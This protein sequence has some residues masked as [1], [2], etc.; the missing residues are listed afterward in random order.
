MESWKQL[1]IHSG[2]RITVPR[3]V[4]MQ[5]LTESAVPMSPKE[6]MACGQKAHTGLGLVTVYRTLDLF[7]QLGLACRVHMAEGCHGYVL[8]QPGHRHILI[9]QQ[10]GQSVEFSGHNDL[11]ALVDR[12]GTRTGFHIADH[13]LQLFGVC[14]TCQVINSTAKDNAE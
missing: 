13:W 11:D 7:E 14:P 4:V 6:I 8:R 3:Q 2:H 1:L 10:C 9:C 12:V 5:V